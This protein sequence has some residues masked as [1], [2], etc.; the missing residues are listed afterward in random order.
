MTVSEAEKSQVPSWEGRLHLWLS[1]AHFGHLRA[2]VLSQLT[3]LLLKMHVSSRPVIIR[4]CLKSPLCREQQ[5]LSGCLSS[6]L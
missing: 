2:V 1:Q 5:L 6:C 4:V 3:S